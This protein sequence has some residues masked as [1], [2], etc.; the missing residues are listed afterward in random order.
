MNVFLYEERRKML[1][2][3]IVYDGKEKGKKYNDFLTLVAAVKKENPKYIV[4]QVRTAAIIRAQALPVFLSEYYATSS[5]HK[6][7]TMTLRKDVKGKKK[8]LVKVEPLQDDKIW[9]MEREVN[10]AIQSA[11]KIA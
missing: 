6:N 10:K 3:K 9:E 2:I 4:K 11:K 8:I 5:V 1:D 7:L